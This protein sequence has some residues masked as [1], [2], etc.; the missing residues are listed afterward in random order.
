[1][2]VAQL[3]EE[4]AEKVDQAFESKRAH[5]WIISLIILN[6]LTLSLS[7]VP[8]IKQNYNLVLQ[9]INKIILG[10]F[11]LE[12]AA[13]MIVTRGLFFRKG[14]N[15]FELIV[16]LVSY[17][18][19]NY[20]LDSL[21]ILRILNCLRLL[22]LFPK[23]RHVIDGLTHSIVG[24]LNVFF[25]GI[26]FFFIF[27]LMATKLFSPWDPE[28]FGSLGSSALFLFNLMATGDFINLEKVYTA[29]PPAWILAISFFIIM[30]YFMV[31]LVVGVVV[32]AMTKAEEENEVRE[33]AT[34]SEQVLVHIAEEMRLLKHEISTLKN[35]LKAEEN[36]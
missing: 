15:V 4:L 26:L 24:I 18:P 12:L 27:T 30:A 5:R 28:N 14:W 9:I 22:E 21:R 29:Y 23:V 2:F 3:T 34:P 20:G 32:N 16:V 11:S 35:F 36:K 10:V 6:A 17:V 7:T 13:R 1:M 8:L 25:L 33:A 19:A 31:N